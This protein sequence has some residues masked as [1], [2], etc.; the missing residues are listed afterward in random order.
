[1]PLRSTTINENIT[2]YFQG[3]NCVNSE[4]ILMNVAYAIIF[5]SEV[6]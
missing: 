2:A 5:S 1:M 3:K 4:V 6:I